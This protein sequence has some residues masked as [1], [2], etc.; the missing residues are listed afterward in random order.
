M[1]IVR[2]LVLLSW[3]IRLNAIH[4]VA[5]YANNMRHHANRIRTFLAEN[6]CSR[7]VTFEF[8]EGDG[9]REVRCTGLKADILLRNLNRYHRVC[10]IDVTIQL[11]SCPRE[12]DQMV[13][14][15]DIVVLREHERAAHTHNIGL[16]CVTKK[17]RTFL[18]R[19]RASM[20]SGGWDQ[21]QFNRIAKSY[22]HVRH[23]PWL[24]VTSGRDDTCETTCKPSNDCWGLKWIRRT[25]PLF[26]NDKF[27]CDT[28]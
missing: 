1:L 19:W 12:T 15:H 16:V 23:V 14:R 6:N 10:V 4:I 8:A 13:Y 9:A 26:S 24:M 27:G 7:D 22:S 25:G 17:A 18:R 21:E 5:P 2:F 3:A 20:S 28:Q 11:L